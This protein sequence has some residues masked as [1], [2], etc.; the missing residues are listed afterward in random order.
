MAFFD[1]SLFVV[2]PRLYR[3]LDR[4][5]DRGAR[6]ARP[7]ARDTGMTGTRPPRMSAVHGLGL[8]DRRRPRRQPQRHRRHHPRDAAHPGRPRAPRLRGGGPATVADHRRHG[9]GRV[10]SDPRSGRSWRATSATCRRPPRMSGGASRRSRTASDWHSSRSGC[11]APGD[12]WSAECAASTAA[13]RRRGRSRVLDELRDALV[14]TGTGP[15]RLWR[16]P[17]AA[18]AGGDVRLPRPRAWR[19]ASTAASIGRALELLR[20][21]DVVERPAGRWHAARGAAGPGGV[22]GRAPRRG[23]GDVPCHRRHP[24]DLRRGRLPSIRHQLHAR[25]AGRPRRAPAGRDRRRPPCAR[26]GAPVRVGGRARGLRG[27]SSTGC[28]PTRATGSTWRD[29]AAARR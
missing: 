1:E 20:E 22:P 21:A 26:C 5:L 8:L 25:R 16:A 9:A 7:P 3:A 29:A 15:G 6:L 2:T 17:G 19:S 23:A 10:G 11:D 13:S 12:T 14:A 4:A 27:R 18:L 24:G 28:C